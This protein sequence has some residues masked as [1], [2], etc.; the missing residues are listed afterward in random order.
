[1]PAMMSLKTSVRQLCRAGLFAVWIAMF[2]QGCSGAD[3][4]PTQPDPPWVINYQKT[5]DQGCKCKSE[6]CFTTAKQKLDT[7]VA[8]HG[9]FDEVPL[10]VH[11][12][13]KGFDPCW[14]AG[15]ADLARDLSKAADA[16]CRCSD[17][18]CVQ[19][20]REGLVKLE[21]KYGT[22]FQPPLADKLTQ[23]AQNEIARATECLAAI[24]IPGEEYLA[25]IEKTTEGICAC[26]ALECMQKILLER[27][28]KFKGY[29]FVDGLV[30]IQS[31]LDVSNANYC[32]CLGKTVA[33]E[34]ADKML[35]GIPAQLN[36]KV[37]CGP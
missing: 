34:A 11:E 30:A 19:T 28:A 8:E 25:F 9:G 21:D 32:Q 31:R 24:S 5:A 12:A 29:V 23:E 36:M 3:I 15:T 27:R 4:Q 16:V 26:D 35:G 6:A 1:M 37:I 22:N 2:A 13:H 20:Y 7:L 14:R 17:N 10:S 18:E 33:Q